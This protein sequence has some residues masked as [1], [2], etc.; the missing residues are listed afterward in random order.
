M[1][2]LQKLNLN[3]T[4]LMTFEATI[5]SNI[6]NVSV[7]LGSNCAKYMGKLEKNI[8]K[9]ISTCSSALHWLLGNAS[10]RKS[11]SFAVR[12]ISEANKGM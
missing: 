3:G 8:K 5:I 10:I 2:A 11:I 1:P 6:F 7:L 12:V 9:N 4:Y